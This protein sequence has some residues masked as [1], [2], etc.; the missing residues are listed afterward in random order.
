MSTTAFTSVVLVV[1]ALNCAASW[2][3]ARATP[4]TPRQVA[5]VPQEDDDDTL[6]ALKERLLQDPNDASAFD[7]ILAKLRSKDS[8]TRVHAAAM[9]GTLSTR[10]D[11][12]LRPRAVAALTPALRDGDQVV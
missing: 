9:I 11:P 2:D 5:K 10:I 7:G 3:Q 4:T 12:R 6:K 8:D 1:V